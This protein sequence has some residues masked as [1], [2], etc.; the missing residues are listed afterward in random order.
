MLTYPVIYTRTIHSQRVTIRYFRRN[1]N[2]GFVWRCQ[3]FINDE[4]WLCVLTF[5]L[6]NSIR[7]RYFSWV[8]EKLK[9]QTYHLAY[10]IIRSSLAVSMKIE[11]CQLLFS[12]TSFQC[13]FILTLNLFQILLDAHCFSLGLSFA[14]C[15]SFLFEIVCLSAKQQAIQI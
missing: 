11:T 2:I 4:S 9:F 15:Q 3:R 13:T 10:M 7:K 5:R 14:I 6:W 12:M 1:N 8:L